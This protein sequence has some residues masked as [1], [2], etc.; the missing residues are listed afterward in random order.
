MFSSFNDPLVSCIS[1]SSEKSNTIAIEIAVREIEEFSSEDQ[2]KALVIVQN[3]NIEVGRSL[4]SGGRLLLTEH[5]LLH[6]WEIIRRHQIEKAIGV[7][8]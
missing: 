3:L 1:S 7:S 5:A 2:T 4:E 8:S 6:L